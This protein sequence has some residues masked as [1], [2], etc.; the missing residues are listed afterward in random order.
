[1]LL[2]PAGE[3]KGAGDGKGEERSRIFGVDM[4]VLVEVL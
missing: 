1:M 2:A 3:M 4:V